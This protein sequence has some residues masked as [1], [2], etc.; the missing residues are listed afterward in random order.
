MKIGSI[1]KSQLPKNTLAFREL[2][3]SDADW[4]IR[5][6]E[7]FRQFVQSTKNPL[8]KLKEEVIKDFEDKLIFRNGGLAGA[9]Y[10]MLIDKLTEDEIETLME[11]FGI[12]R[13]YGKGINKHRC[14]APG[15][16]RFYVHF[17]CTDNC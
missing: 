14:T 5:T 15:N 13:E 8:S 11:Y 2:M 10:S 4:F 3:D 6:L 7:D 12:S 17:Y 9:D 1:N 16:C